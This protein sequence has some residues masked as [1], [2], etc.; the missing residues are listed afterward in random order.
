MKDALSI[1]LHDHLAGAAFGVELVEA[2]E[3]DHRG[4]ELGHQ[5]AAWKI[6][7]IADQATLR[8]LVDRIGADHDTIKEVISW[9]AHK[10]SRL[11]LRR[12]SHGDLG[13]F[14]TLEALA[15]GILGKEKLWQALQ[16]CEVNDPRLSGF[17]FV[18]LEQRAREQHQRV[19]AYRIQFASSAFA[20][21]S[22]A[23]TRI[24]TQH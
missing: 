19:E 8:D 15:L 21:S 24:Q 22:A 7:I 3:H 11:K 14:E 23:E 12:Q 16:V 13:T 18:G 1:Y 9:I 4:D 5:A 10:T 17:D 6:E 2:L 20:A